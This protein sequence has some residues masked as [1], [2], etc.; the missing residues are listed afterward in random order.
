MHAHASEH[1]RRGGRWQAALIV[2]I[3]FFAVVGAAATGWWYARESPPH[4]GPIVVISVD[5]A[6]ASSLP[7]YG[8]APSSTPAI[9]AFSADAVIFDRAYA[10]SPQLLPAEASLLSG[11][12]PFEHGVRDDA[13]FALGAETRTLAELL[14][15]R[16]FAT[17]AAVSSFLLRR[18]SGIAQGFSFFD[19]SLPLDRDADNTSAF[20][21]ETPVLERDGNLTMT[22]AEDWLRT[23]AGQR[24]FL[25]VQVNAV[26]ADESVARISEL[27]KERRLYNDA[28]IVVVGNR[29]DPGAAGLSLDEAAL[30]IP[31]LVKQPR[32]AGAGRRVSVS[33]QH[34]D[35][36]PTVL[37]LVRAPLPGGLRGRSLRAILDDDTGE[38]DPQPIYAEA[39]TAMF[40]FGGDPLFAL[41]DDQFRYLRGVD[42][43][44]V[45]IVPRPGVEEGTTATETVIDRLR[46]ALDRLLASA[47]DDAPRVVIAASDEERFALSGYLPGPGLTEVDS[48]LTANEQKT[49]VAEHRAAAVLVGQKKYSAG[50]RALQAI[51]REY[52]MLT[53]VHYQLGVLFSRTGRFDESIASFR[54]ARQLR[55]ESPALA[56]ALAEAQMRAGLLDPA[57][58]T[59]VEA[60]TL[61]EAEEG[62]AR[63]RA[64]AHVV[65]AR[66]ALARMDADA[67][68]AH[69]EAANAADPAVPAP[70]FVRGRLLYQQGQY[71]EALEAFRQA[72]AAL[73]EHG[74]TMAD[75]HLYLGESLAR[76]EQYA[77]AETQFREELLAFPRNTQA[78]AS[79]AMVYRAA[80]RDDA[81]ED[82]LSEL[83]A[84]TPTPEGYA[85][86]ARL[87]TALGD[88]SRA[89]AL[90]SDARTRF[91][92]DPS[93]ALLG[94]D[95]RR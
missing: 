56:L 81:I 44:L 46:M 70:Q 66:V 59:S 57:Q 17:G 22:A 28:T 48:D 60:V 31:L 16:G 5:Q 84:A 6:P 55:P 49:L 71:E 32:G 78:Y 65:A 94:H 34:I 12:L 10:H 37:D 58:Q 26:D 74:G 20:S 51:V 82:V 25:F 43:E 36:L 13:G 52:P 73:R 14:R 53:A 86:A 1:N 47:R 2:T 95:A 29:G 62:D 92:G 85:V 91:R 80:N 93:L 79:L 45:E 77:E 30:R 42:E 64:E 35:L 9:D 50:I 83:V 67:A 63:E 61:A 88:R 41:A 21:T 27:L 24:F 23:Q 3:F 15:N 87:W 4:Q 76:L 7:A 38:V 40:R 90:T 39:L 72:D 75:L 69:A 68:M 54:T 18:E 89:E 33:V 8:A 19:A 11:Q